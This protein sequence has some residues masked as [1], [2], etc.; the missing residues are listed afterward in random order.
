MRLAMR[1]T[2][3]M[4]TK[5]WKG[6]SHSSIFAASS[7]LIVRTS[8]QNSVGRNKA[9]ALGALGAL[10]SGMAFS[11]HKDFQPYSAMVAGTLVSGGQGLA[12][13]SQTGRRD[14]RVA[15]RMAAHH[16][17]AGRRQHLDG[18][19]APS[20]RQRRAGVSGRYAMA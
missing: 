8:A 10:G 6:S 1:F 7:G 3:R 5:L 11:L 12:N 14:N 13:S 18:G 19:I 9:G 2:V 17:H 4:L 16:R 15:A 20:P